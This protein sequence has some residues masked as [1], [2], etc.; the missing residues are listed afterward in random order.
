MVKDS[1]QHQLMTPIKE[2]VGLNQRKLHQHRRVNLVAVAEGKFI[3]ISLVYIALSSQKR[4][5]INI[6]PELKP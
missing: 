1:Y 2:L 4:Q 5:L 3:P 6:I